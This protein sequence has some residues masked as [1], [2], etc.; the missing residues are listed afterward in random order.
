MTS[1]QELA[2]MI[3]KSCYLCQGIMKKKFTIE[4]HLAHKKCIKDF[5]KRNR[6]GI[7]TR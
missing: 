1:G 4:G 5:V 2:R 7:W 3:K 6:N